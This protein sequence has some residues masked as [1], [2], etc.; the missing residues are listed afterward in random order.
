MILTA[1]KPDEFGIVVGFKH[2]TLQCSVCQDMECAGRRRCNVFEG[3]SCA[4]IR[5]SFAGRIAR[6]AFR[7]QLRQAKRA[8]LRRNST[9][10][11]ILGQPPYPARSAACALNATHR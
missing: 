5:P 4:E 8:A 6:I 7:S 2:E 11:E 3:D 9:L 1:V 10:Q